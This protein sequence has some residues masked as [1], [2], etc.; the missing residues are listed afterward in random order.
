MSFS[1]LIYK[2][3]NEHQ[4]CHLHHSVMRLSRATVSRPWSHGSN[5]DAREQMNG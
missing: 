3:E 2:T 4:P 1:F 5:L